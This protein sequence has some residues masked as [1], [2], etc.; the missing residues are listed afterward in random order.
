[1]Q[2]DNKKYVF[3]KINICK[4]PKYMNATQGGRQLRI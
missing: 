2:T 3:R 1:M 4:L